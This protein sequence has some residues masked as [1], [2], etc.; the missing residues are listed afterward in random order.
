MT[1]E[2]LILV[3]KISSLGRAIWPLGPVSLLL[4]RPSFAKGPLLLAGIWGISSSAVVVWRHRSQSFFQWS[5]LST[6]GRHTDFVW[7]PVGL[8]LIGPESLALLGCPEWTK[9][10]NHLSLLFIFLGA[11]QPFSHTPIIENE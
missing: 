1:T 6:Q 4:M 11:F 7:V 8:G 5:H 3:V 10:C 2:V 9:P